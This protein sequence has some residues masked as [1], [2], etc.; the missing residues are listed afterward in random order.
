[1][2]GVSFCIYYMDQVKNFS[3]FGFSYILLA[4]FKSGGGMPLDMRDLEI[5]LAVVDCG[6]LT[7][8]QDV[9]N[10]SSSALSYAVNRIGKSVNAP[11]FN[12]GQRGMQLTPAGEEYVKTAREMIAIRDQT[13]QTIRALYARYHEHISIGLSPHID[14][15]ILIEM[16]ERFHTMYPN[17][18]VDV[19]EC[20]S[21][22]AVS[23]VEEGRLN[24]AI[25]I[26]DQEYIRK[27]ELTFLPIQRVEYLIA[28]AEG[29][30]LAQEGATRVRN[31]RDVP[32]RPL[33]DFSD[34]PYIG[35]ER[36]A[37]S[38]RS[39]AGGIFA[40][41]GFEPLEIATT[42]NIAFS[43]K[44][45]VRNNAYTFLPLDA[46]EENIGLRYYRSEPRITILKGLYFRPSFFFSEAVRDFVS[47]YAE[48]FKRFYALS[49]QLYPSVFF[50]PE[51]LIK[52]FG[53]E[54]QYV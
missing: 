24:L 51:T 41:A 14:A 50:V 32:S 17:V 38:S 19:M 35:Y 15:S 10:L 28:I 31:G 37:M 54:G 12:R 53:Q 8:A 9:L 26:E 47:C 1:M 22:E 4:K 11:L 2:T 49:A 25:G 18:A 20:Y 43:K 52:Q 13:Y 29:N 48:E 45:I 44:L 23:A 46:V 42:G 27:S 34:V 40:A 30:S 33:V 16:Y 3:I 36:R 6:S 5:I 7:K 21:H 39:V